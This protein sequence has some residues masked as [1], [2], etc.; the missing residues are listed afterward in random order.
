MGP[1]VRSHIHSFLPDFLW[2]QKPTSS[3]FLG[4]GGLRPWQAGEARSAEGTREISRNQGSELSDATIVPQGD[5]G[6]TRSEGTHIFSPGLHG[7]QGFRLP[8]RWVVA[9]FRARRLPEMSI[10]VSGSRATLLEAAACGPN[11]CQCG[12]L[13]LLRAAGGNQTLFERLMA[14]ACCSASTRYRLFPLGQ[15]GAGIELD[16]P[17]RTPAPSPMRKHSP[18]QPSR[19][20][21]STPPLLTSPQCPN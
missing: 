18:D 21:A 9:N 14:M 2:K 19:R 16:A 10:R 6:M 11:F 4:W 7:P 15:G 8:G 13:P 5:A 1:S 20:C 3:S 12:R 17:S